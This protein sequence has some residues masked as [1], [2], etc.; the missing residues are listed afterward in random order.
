MHIGVFGVLNKVLFQKLTGDVWQ[1]APF[2]CRFLRFLHLLSKPFVS[3]VGLSFC[4]FC[5][6]LLSFLLVVVV[7]QI[8]LL[9]S[10]FCFCCFGFPWFGYV[11]CVVFFFG[12]VLVGFLFWRVSG[13]GE[14]AQRATSIGPKPSLFV[15][16]CFWFVF[17]CF[18]L[19]V[20]FCLFF[21]FCF[22]F[23]FGR[24]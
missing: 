2:F 23:C 19:V 5:F 11:L 8:K 1:K 17:V 10:G 7:W 12:L 9:C 15:L 3:Y 14:V 18:V 21:C 16:F 24:V 22:C 20:G 6:S 4:W 13:S